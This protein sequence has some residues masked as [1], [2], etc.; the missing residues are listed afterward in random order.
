MKKVLLGTVVACIMLFSFS[1]SASAEEKGMEISF[2]E[3]ETELLSYLENK[4]VRYTINS[5]EMSDYLLDQLLNGTDKELEQHN[6]YDDIMAYAA[7]YIYRETSV[8]DTEVENITQISDFTLQDIKDEIDFEETIALE[9]RNVRFSRAVSSYNR[10]N[11]VNYA[12]KHAKSYNK[13]YGNYNGRGGDCTNFASQVLR[14][15]GA[16]DGKTGYPTNY[17][18]SSKRSNTGL[19]DS[20]AWINAN[21]FRLY[22]QINAR[23]VTR[24]T[25]KSD[26][27]KK[28]AKGDILN[29]ANKKTGRSWHNAIVTDKKNNTLYVSQHTSDRRNDNWNSISI[30]FNNDNVYVIKPN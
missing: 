21:S 27:S 2:G 15:G 26:A 11:A 10:N 20:A 16:K 29:Y 9:N 14:A 25:S 30:N 28:A 8:E 24:H 7:E 19:K 23:S 1:N 6:N 5:R 4:G 17:D 3:I 22:W 13:S 18:W 12:L